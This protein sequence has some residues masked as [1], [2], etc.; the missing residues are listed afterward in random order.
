M[1]NRTINDDQWHYLTL[2]RSSSEIAL[3]IDGSFDSIWTSAPTGALTIE[4][5]GLWLGGDQD[6]VGGCWERVGGLIQ[7]SVGNLVAWG[8]PLTKRSG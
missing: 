8:V 3:Y 5:S 6:C 4:T 7:T 1:S 2:I